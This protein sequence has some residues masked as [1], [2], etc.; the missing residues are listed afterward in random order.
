[1]TTQLTQ[2]WKDQLARKLEEAIDAGML[3]VAAA[4]QVVNDDF[5]FDSERKPKRPVSLGDLNQQGLLL[6][7]I[8][9]S[10]R[11]PCLSEKHTI[12]PPCS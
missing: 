11:L 1:M 9:A 5:E 2:E 7:A 10:N 8:L 12:E 6:I 3:P 4:G